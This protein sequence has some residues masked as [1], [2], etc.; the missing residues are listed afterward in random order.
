MDVFVKTYRIEGGNIQGGKSIQEVPLLE[1]SEFGEVKKYLEEEATE[2][3]MD[4]IS[5]KTEFLPKSFFADYTPQTPYL[6]EVQV[7]SGWDASDSRCIFYGPIKKKSIK[8]NE[9]TG[10]TSFEVS[11]WERSVKQAGSVV[12]RE[13]IPVKVA[14]QYVSDG[15]NVGPLA[16]WLGFGPKVRV[17]GEDPDI[18]DIIERGMILKTKA[19]LGDNT[20]PFHF[21]CNTTLTEPETDGVTAGGQTIYQ[22]PVLSGSS[23]LFRGE[24]S[25]EDR[26]YFPLKHTGPVKRHNNLG[27]HVGWNDKW[28][29]SEK[30]I[31]LPLSSFD[32]D[33]TEL[34]G[35]EVEITVDES[36]YGAGVKTTKTKVTNAFVA[37]LIDGPK[38]AIANLDTSGLERGEYG[39]LVFED[40]VGGSVQRGTFEVPTNYSGDP[41]GL[42]DMIGAT[43]TYNKL[44]TVEPGTDGTL[45]SSEA[46]GREGGSMQP[47]GAVPLAEGVA[48][49][50]PALADLLDG[51]PVVKGTPGSLSRRIQFDED[52]IKALGDIQRSAEAHISF[53]ARSRDLEGGERKDVTDAN[54]NKIGEGARRVKMVVATRDYQAQQPTLD[55]PDAI[56]WKGEA[57]GAKP[58][59]V[60]VEGPK[61]INASSDR[62]KAVGWF[63][64]DAIDDPDRA[65]EGGNEV[66]KIEAPLIEASVEGN[67][68]TVP[69]N[70]S[71]VA[72][73]AERYYNFYSQYFREKE[74][75]VDGV[76]DQVA[77]GAYED[78]VIGSTVSEDESV[79]ETGVVTSQSVDYGKEETTLNVLVATSYVAPTNADPVALLQAPSALQ[80][81][82]GAVPI[83]LDATSSYDPNGD[84]ISFRWLKNG[85]VITGETG[86]YLETD[87]QDGDQYEV[88]VK[89]PEGAIDV[90]TVTINVST[91]TTGSSGGEPYLSVRLDEGS[92][93]DTTEV[94]DV[95]SQKRGG[96]LKVEYKVLRGD[97]LLSEGEIGTGG[98]EASGS[99]SVDRN[100]RFLKT[101]TVKSYDQTDGTVAR[102]VRTVAPASEASTGTTLG[103][104]F[105][106]NGDA[107]EDEWAG[108]YVDRGRREDGTGSGL[109][110]RAVAW[111]PTTDRFGVADLDAANG[112]GAV[113]STFEQ[114]ALASADETIDGSWKFGAQTE[115]RAEA[116]FLTNGAKFNNHIIYSPDT[117]YDVLNMRRYGKDFTLLNMMAPP[118]T[119]WG[120]ARE[121]TLALVRGDGN[122]YFMDLYNMDYGDSDQGN[123][124]DYGNARMGLRLQKRGTGVYTPFFFEYSDGTRG[125]EI[126]AMVMYPQQSTNSTNDTKI[127]VVNEFEVGGTAVIG[128]HIGSPSYTSGILGAGWRVD[129]TPA[130]GSFF[131][132]DN[133]RVRNEFRTHIFKKDIVKASNGYLLITDSAKVAEGKAMFQDGQTLDVESGEGNASF[134]VNDL[135]WVKTLDD[136]GS[137]VYEIKLTVTAVDASPGDKDIL[138]VNVQSAGDVYEGDTLV[139]VSGGYLLNDASSQYAPFIDV[140]DGV[141]T[142][143]DFRHPNKLKARYGNLEGVSHPTMNPSG[144]GLYSENTYLEGEFVAGSGTTHIKSNGDLYLADG[145]IT[146]NGITLEVSAKITALS[147]DIAGWSITHNSLDKSF[148]NTTLNLG[149]LPSASDYGFRAASSSGREVF[150]RVDESA[151]QA[152]IGAYKDSANHVAIGEDFWGIMNGVGVRIRSAGTDV[153]QADEDGLKVDALF[154]DEIFSNEATISERLT[155]GS[156]GEITNGA[157]DYTIDSD[158]IALNTGSGILARAITWNESGTEIAR[159][160]ADNGSY[161]QSVYGDANSSY[162][163]QTLQARS[164][165]GSTGSYSYCEI[166][167]S[168]RP[169]GSDSIQ[170][171][172]SDSDGVYTNDSPRVEIGTVLG[173]NTDVMLQFLPNEKVMKFPNYRTSHYPWSA[174]NQGEAVLYVMKK[175]DGDIDLMWREKTD[176][177][178][179]YQTNLGS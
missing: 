8:Y 153:L 83:T 84:P 3:R 143:S 2:F 164:A 156:T 18:P 111:N 127:E 110:S 136:A 80:S 39:I 85:S 67:G 131:E 10:V 68:L 35:A 77:G 26:A 79:F 123:Y 41:I 108:F 69:E 178:S 106:A 139:R 148:T 9:R 96:D 7:G 87:A 89:D 24:G 98:P 100:N 140:Y 107:I 62:D 43:W 86:R 175:G 88:E 165:K 66:V 76:F 22:F 104:F 174:L 151:D 34:V 75:V 49:R 63:P 46:Y 116:D 94:Y 13:R 125:E 144:Y 21:L 163:G 101:I 120:G 16:Q 6:V 65:D 121:C 56:E 162:S 70:I 54:N 52:L 53:Q 81:N 154:T 20:I 93:T 114:F 1:V 11:S 12:A 5:L 44:L 122:E 169:T 72:G 166:A 99:I 23:G 138:T 38:G 171:N 103:N 45:L 149:T 105:T 145:D 134:S 61:I 113:E 102:A 27:Q 59:V 158:G 176:D 25:T 82:D 170:L 177:G 48:T 109:I 95:E 146:Y 160:A 142:W 58:D 78:P 29:M 73:R 74:V 37:P 137:T 32:S 97:E 126:E 57:L 71:S 55:L 141:S 64:K 129:N 47:Y 132:V 128:E 112:G 30:K 40:K 152:E 14:K 161:V 168:Y 135:L 173:G 31:A 42:P 133:M 159:I 4:S 179:T 147:G 155:I 33:V 92:T 124:L 19:K 50:T 172:T 15:S 36:V 51:S 130:E 28:L 119:S 167:I 150:M 17:A 118:Q 115:F 90:D 91:A 157:G 60:V 117:T